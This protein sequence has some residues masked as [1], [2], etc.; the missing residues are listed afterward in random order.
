[1]I[2]IL[3]KQNGMTIIGQGGKII[4][5]TLPSLVA[6]IFI[7]L[8]FPQIAALPESIR[9]ITPLGYLLILPGFMLWGAAVFQLL[10]GF[11]DGKLVTTGAYGIVRNP[12]YSSVTFFILPG[13]ALLT[14]TWVYFV[15]AIFLYAGVIIF[16]G[17]E[18]QQLTNAFGKEYEDYMARVDRLVLFKNPKYT[19]A[20]PLPEQEDWREK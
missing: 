7:H 6:A 4:L 19:P 5:F 14:L 18:E 2:N 3:K 1:M 16:I 20:F 17:T 10:T 11:S 8:Y 12:I 13:L 15:P 9:F